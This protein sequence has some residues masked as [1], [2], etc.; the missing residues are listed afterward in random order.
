MTIIVTHINTRLTAATSFETLPNNT[1]QYIKTQYQDTGKLLDIQTSLSSDR[2]TRTG[3]LTFKDQSAVSEYY[4]DPII[5]EALTVIRAYNS[6]N[7]I[8]N[9]NITVNA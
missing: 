5:A 6:A 4:N 8:D 3:I 2:L 1:V 9:K 7:G